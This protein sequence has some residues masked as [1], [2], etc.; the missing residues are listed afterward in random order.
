MNFTDLVNADIKE[1]NAAA[2]R[3]NFV[4]AKNLAMEAIQNIKKCD[5]EDRPA[6]L[7]KVKRL[8][9]YIEELETNKGDWL[10]QWYAGSAGGQSIRDV[11]NNRHTTIKI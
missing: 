6:L 10:A 1:S 8:V 5:E 7:T 9:E 11:K 3:N 2:E 4:T